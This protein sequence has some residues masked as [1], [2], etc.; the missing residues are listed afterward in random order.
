MDQ[1]VAPPASTMGRGTS[2][3]SRRFL[4]SL[5]V[6]IGAA[7]LVVLVPLS[8]GT[9]WTAVARSLG[10]VSG[11]ELA[12][13]T[14]LWLSGL[15]AHSWVLTA[16]LP[17]LTRRRA[18]TLNLSGSAVAN[19]LPAGGAAGVGLNF[20]MVRSWGFSSGRFATYTVVSNVADVAAKLVVAV[21]GF[22]ALLLAGR[23]L[24]LPGSTVEAVVAGLVPVLALFAISLGSARAARAVGVFGDRL[25]WVTSTLV[26]APR[27]TALA[28]KLPSLRSTAVRALA[29]AWQQITLGMAAYVSL[30][31]LL[32]WACLHV[33][34]SGLGATAVLAALA[35]DRLLTILPLTPGGAGVVEAG[36]A[37]ALVAL[38]ALP[39]TATAAVLLFRAFTFAM[40]IPVGGV[41][42]GLWLLRRRRSRGAEAAHADQRGAVTL[43]QPTLPRPTLPRPAGRR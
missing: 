13:L 4:T 28:A 11:V 12:E 27:R 31:G 8:V 30:Q 22:G 37:A 2:L 15:W 16:S 39:V 25:I 19:V 14:A 17:G 33:L 35:V 29:S 32:L 34:G 5:L 40:E 3:V 43:P 7:A 1:R 41:I 42:G 20:A 24:Q 23:S 26:R 6:G 18:L 9:S 36:S 38:G 21:V 10:R